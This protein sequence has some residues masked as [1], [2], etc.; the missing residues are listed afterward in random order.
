MTASRLHPQVTDGERRLLTMV[1]ASLTT[2]GI[3]YR[4]AVHR[5]TVRRWK[6]SVYRKL[7]AVNAASAVA[8][9]IRDG[10]INVGGPK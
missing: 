3:A 2:D 4:L 8:I 5:D 1:A 10:L 6:T 7:G 9:A